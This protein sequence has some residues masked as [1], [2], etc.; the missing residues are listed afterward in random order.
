MASIMLPEVLERTGL[1]AREFAAQRRRHAAPLPGKGERYCSDE[2]EAYCALRRFGRVVRWRWTGTALD[3]TAVR[4][5]PFASPVERA[6]RRAQQKAEHES[7]E[8][9]LRLRDWAV[10]GVPHDAALTKAQLHALAG[11]YGPQHYRLPDARTVRNYAA[12]TGLS[13]SGSTARLAALRRI[14]RGYAP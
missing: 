12:R 1:T 14:A 9:D 5:R 3:V 4:G 8:I 11:F 10:F 2:I 7:G 13:D 6:E